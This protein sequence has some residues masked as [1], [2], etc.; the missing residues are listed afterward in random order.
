M[1]IIL[2]AFKPLLDLRNVKRVLKRTRKP[3]NTFRHRPVSVRLLAAFALGTLGVQAQQ[4]LWDTEP[5]YWDVA[6]TYQL[7]RPLP[8]EFGVEGP[9]IGDPGQGAITANNPQGAAGI[10]LSNGKLKVSLWGPANR[11]TLSISKTDVYD[12][13][14]SHPGTSWTPDEGHSPRPVGQLLLLADDFAGAPQPQVTTA[15]SNCVSTFSLKQ[16]GASA[17]LTYF[18]T[19]SNRNVL[20]IQANCTGLTKPALV[21]VFNFQ[22]PGKE[23]PVSGNDGTYFWLRQT[24]PAEKTFPNGF[25]YYFMAKVVGTNVTLANVDGA[26]GMGSPTFG[27]DAGCAATAT[28]APGATTSF[29]VYATVV[30]QA[31]TSNPLAEAR[32]RLD[33]AEHQGVAALVA[34]N[35]AWCQSLYERRERGRIFTGDFSN[36]LK[37]IL[38]PFFYEGSWQNRHAYMSSPDPSKYEGDA[39]YAGLE[40]EA[41]PWYGIFCFNEELYTGDFVAGRDETIAPYYVTLI[42]FWRQAWE[43]HAIDA[44]KEGMYFIRGYVPPVKNDVYYSYDQDAMQGNDYATMLWCYK[45]VWN[46]YD[47]GGRDDAFLRTSV[48]P[49]LRDVADFFGSLVTMGDDGFYH[50]DQCEM[51]ENEFGR[52]AMDCVASA[53]WFWKRAIEA[54][55]TL[56]TDYAKRSQWKDFLNKMAPYY[57][58]PDGTLGGIVENGQVRQFKMLQHFVVNEADEYNLESSPEER[59]RAYDS[60]DHTFLGAD[61]PTL[62]G[63]DP[64]TF[65]GGAPNWFWMF[66]RQPWLM[67]YAIKV[68]G[69]GINGPTTLDTPIKKTVACWF[70]PERLCNSRSGTIFFFPCVPSHFDVAFKEM[71]ARGG[72]LVTGELRKG[73][74][75]YAQVKARREAVCAVMDPWPDKSLLITQA[76]ENVPVKTVHTGNKYRFVAEAGK[77]YLLSPAP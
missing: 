66:C 55:V 16:G 15:I 73:V 48:Y 45:N 41:A 71:Q 74:V 19:R 14:N 60:T 4:H 31:E 57:V 5:S 68:L 21:R 58:M 17:D 2:K 64:D 51:R 56:N 23:S 40:V 13:S 28:V 61:I 26:T 37:D 33:D 42:N 9:E 77:T 30:T 52:D 8:A 3:M 24:L 75:T 59:Q 18:S 47:Y 1:R 65:T 63:R 70:E 72:F 44:G 67:Y 46:E 11:L 25:E 27:R 53:K 7:T 50:I 12:R 69:P 36:D 35:Q 54:S 32:K 29:V 38:M 43:K 49:G 22:N 20:V 39:C 62:L 76:P 6:K 10:N 34:E